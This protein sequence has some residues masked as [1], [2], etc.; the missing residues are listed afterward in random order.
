MQSTITL[1]LTLMPLMV[2]LVALGRRTNIPYPIFLVLGGLAISLIPGLPSFELE[3]D[4]VF[5][6]ILPP[7]LTAAGY[8]TPI[9]DFRANL[10]SIGLL[11]VGLV[12]FTILI[13]G[14]VARMVLPTLSW[15]AAFVLGAI[16]APPDAV[17]ATSVAN[18]LNM[19]RR[20]ITLL[21]GESLLNDATALVA[22][23]V[24]LVA[25]LTGAFSLGEAALDFVWAMIGG[26][27]I[28]LAVAWPTNKI[29]R[30]LDDTPVEVLITFAGCFFTYLI[31][32]RLHVSGVLAT[33]ALG[34]YYGVHSSRTFSPKTRVRGL[35]V[36]EVVV[37]VLNS[38]V[39]I[40]IGLQLPL[41]IADLS[42][43]PLGQLLWAAVGVCLAV[44]ISR[45]AWLFPTTYI[46]RWL[47]PKLRQRDPSPPWQEVAVLGWAG[48]R[49]IVSL[50]AAL[51]LPASLPE[52]DLILF[53]T[54]SVILAT[55]VG[56][57]LTLPWVVKRV[58]VVD[59]GSFE[60]E[61]SKARQVAAQAGLDRLAALD[62]EDWVY[63]EHIDDLRSHYSQ[64]VKRFVPDPGAGEQAASEKSVAALNRLQ[65]ELLEAEQESL[66]H[67]RDEGT[68]NDEALRHVQH[69]L[70]L[71]QLRLD[72]RE[73]E[74]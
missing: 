40:L 68:I 3:P 58:G 61:V 51:A 29:L 5:L 30:R 37:F 66:I 63:S 49:G 41:V 26:I 69:E 70:D 34:L 17:A 47:S 71:A 62:G 59:D 18:R 14:I 38:A 65:R 19:P 8:F 43:E 55:L 27:A 39:F 7:I 74:S 48:M 56:Q 4:L 10:R 28:G 33:V 21:E 13:V 52:R 31:A 46:P 64:R 16:V 2:L 32:E 22:Y 11:A 12:L 15:G 36:W 73:L 45:F 25:A 60:R 57:G 53:L 20:L 42:G 67:L 1:F 54:F 50:A 6:L 72:N 9:R 44:I 35:A 24:A 23:R